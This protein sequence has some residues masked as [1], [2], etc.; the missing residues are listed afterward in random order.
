MRDD[1]RPRAWIVNDINGDMYPGEGTFRSERAC[2]EHIRQHL[3]GERQREYGADSMFG[4]EPV[5]RPAAMVELLAR[6]GPALET[7]R[8]GRGRA[9]AKDWERAL[10][11]VAGAAGKRTKPDP[12]GLRDDGDEEAADG[13]EAADRER[14]RKLIE[15][16]DAVI[17]SRETP[18]DPYGPER[19]LQAALTLGRAS[20]EAEDRALAAA[21]GKGTIAGDRR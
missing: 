3:D 2:E 5:P 16:A 20:V 17:E 10:E 21:S 6:R 1:E 19:D 4:C 15:A 13:S 12:T 8:T 14:V 18:A 11:A 7:D 9:A